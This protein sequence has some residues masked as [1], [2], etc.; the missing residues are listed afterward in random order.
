MKLSIVIP[1][2]NEEKLL[3]SC[4]RSVQAALATGLRPGWASE[5]V[6]CDNNS[7]DKTPEIARAEG[8]QVVFEPHNQISRARN[9]G[10]KAASGDWLLFID[11]DSILDPKV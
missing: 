11:A 8:A 2:F 5:V 10:A 9:T 6:V 4:L 1:A 3:A 7:T